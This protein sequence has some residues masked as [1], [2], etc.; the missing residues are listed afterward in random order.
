MGHEILKPDSRHIVDRRAKSDRPA[1]IRRA[2]L[3]FI[4]QVRILG[5]LKCHAADHIPATHVRGHRLQYGPLPIQHA[6]PRR[7]EQLMP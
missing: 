4:R 1:D 7:P 3:K 6:D 2:R 5:L